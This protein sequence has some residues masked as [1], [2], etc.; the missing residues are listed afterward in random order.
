MTEDYIEDYEISF[1]F[2]TP[3][4]NVLEVVLNEMNY[5]HTWASDNGL[6]CED[7]LA[8]AIG[9]LINNFDISF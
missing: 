6:D 2:I 5:L 4:E 7:D 8:K 1:N 9:L 3:D